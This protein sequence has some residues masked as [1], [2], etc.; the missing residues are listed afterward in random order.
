MQQIE[1]L[2][3]TLLKQH[4]LNE[5]GFTWDHAKT[6]FGSCDHS[7]KEITLSKFL[8]SKREI[9]EVRNTI[10]HEIAHAL[11]GHRNGH[12]KMW[13]AKA[14]EIGCDGQRCSNDVIVQ[15]S[16]KGACPNC[17]TEIHRHRRKRVSCSKCDS[18]FNPKYLFTWERVKPDEVP[19]PLRK[20]FQLQLNF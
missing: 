1:E 2:A 19:Q 20:P 13:R 11:V 18:R 14:L 10:L 7:R 15:A 5:W 9:H 3:I 12:N 4:G 17:R 8:T 16:F 6:R